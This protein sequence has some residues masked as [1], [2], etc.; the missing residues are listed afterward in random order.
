MTEINHLEGIESDFIETPVL[1]MHVLRAGEPGNPPVLFL[2]GNASSSTIWEEIMLQLADEYYCVAPDLRGFGETDP[3][4]LIDA[5]RGTREW[6]VDI[7]ALLEELKLPAV[8]LVGHSLGGFIC[9]GLIARYPSRIRTASLVAPGPPM[10]FGGLKGPEGSPNNED[11]SGSGAGIVVEEL[12]RRIQA[13]DRSEEDPFFSPRNAMNRLFWK[14]GFRAQREEAFLTAM[15][16]IHCGPK[17]YPG[18]FRESDYWPGVQPGKYGPVN[19]MAPQYN[20]EVMDE[21]L[22]SEPKPPLLWIQG[23]DDQIISDQSL[24]DPGFQG[25]LGLR[26]GWPGAAEYPPQPMKQQVGYALQQYRRHGGQTALLK[27]A[28]CGHSPFVEQPQL[29]L[30]A[31]LKHF[32][33]D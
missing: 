24:S 29:V 27:V 4:A 18:D 13:G 7:D 30:K 8:H 31:L 2:H 15:L 11:Y 22:S 32:R 14:E 25:M 6:T 1:R 10:G 9:W 21:L 5:T 28:D 20:R 16:A 33:Q 12:A 3:G 17:Q 26:P 19:A 23:E